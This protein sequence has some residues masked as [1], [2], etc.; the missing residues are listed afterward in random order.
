MSDHSAVDPVAPLRRLAVTPP[1]APEPVEALRARVARRQ[2]RRQRGRIGAASVA[3]AAVVA[4]MVTSWSPRDARTL[5][6]AGDPGSTTP[7]STGSGEDD[8]P[9]GATSC[10][11]ITGTE[12]RVGDHL[13]VDVPVGFAPD[14]VVRE[15]STGYVDTGGE[16]HATL[17]L[18][19]AQGRWIEVDSFGTGDPAALIG[20]LAAGAQ[21][22]EVTAP[23]CIEVAGGSERITASF[24]VAR[25]PD[26][27]ILAIQEWE[28]GGVSVTGGPG[29]PIGELL[30]VAAGLRNA[31]PSG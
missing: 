1:A 10:A 3:L 4:L 12:L 11:R 9:E 15:T 30:E 19:D 18:S 7:T 24:L 14:G 21:T 25:H 20:A 26:R 5:R 22:E 17:R 6:T 27:T 16:G 8:A 23:R 28:Y 31:P 2:R 13:V 29:V